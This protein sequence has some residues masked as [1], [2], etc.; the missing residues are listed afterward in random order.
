MSDRPPFAAPFRCAFETE[1]ARHQAR[2]LGL[3]FVDLHEYDISPGI[4]RRVSVAALARGNR[5]LAAAMLDRLRPH[6]GETS[7]WRRI[8]FHHHAANWSQLS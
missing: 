5:G 8:R 2:A 4:L 6:A 3:P 1:V 7:D